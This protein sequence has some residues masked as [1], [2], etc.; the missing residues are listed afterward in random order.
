MSISSP[1]PV[2]RLK[3]PQRLAMSS[4]EQFGLY[5]VLSDINQKH[6]SI[7]IL[8]T[9]ALKS[10]RWFA[11]ESPDCCILVVGHQLNKW[12]EANVDLIHKMAK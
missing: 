4:A 6:T 2:N 5:Q 8:P 11:I 7:K 12:L 9:S 1:E 3:H 10:W